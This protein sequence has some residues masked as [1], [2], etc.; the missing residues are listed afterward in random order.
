MEKTMQQTFECVPKSA[1]IQAVYRQALSLAQKSEVLLQS[2]HLVIALF[3]V[4]NKAEKLLREREI[5]EDRLLNALE[6][7]YDEPQDTV[8][9]IIALSEQQASR[10]NANEEDTLHLL[11]ACC[12][13]RSSLAYRMLSR[14]FKEVNELLNQLNR[15]LTGSVKR[16]FDTHSP[17]SYND[18]LSTSASIS[19]P[20]G[21]FSRPPSGYPSHPTTP[22]PPTALPPISS[23]NMS[24]FPPPSTLSHPPH[25]AYTQAPESSSRN[26]TK[27]PQGSHEEQARAA[28]KRATHGRLPEEFFP[29]L[30]QYGRNLTEAAYSG[31]FDPLIGR[32]KEIEHLLDILGKR[33]TNNPCILGDSGVGKTALVQGLACALLHTENPHLR[34]KI[35]IELE[36]GNLLSGT[37]MRGSLSEKLKAIK[38]E[39]ALANGQII[40]FIDEIHTL[41]RTGGGG[42]SPLDI[43]NEL[44]AALASG[45]FPCIG[46]TTNHEY[47]MH[48]ER[49]PALLR[50]FHP[51]WLE[52]PTQEEAITILTSLLRTIYSIHHK[53][54]YLPE[55]I[56]E[57]V[58]L[59]VRYLPE[60]RLPAKA[61]DILDQAGSYVRRLQQHIVERKH[62][63]EI[64]AKTA[65]IAKEHLL[66]EDNYR[67]L[68][69]EDFLKERI[70]GHHAILHQIAHALRR[71]YAGFRGNRPIGSFLFLGSTGTGK[72]EMAKALA[73][74]FFHHPQA[75]VRFDM[76][77]FQESNS[78]SRLIGAP[79]G[80]VGHEEGG[81]LTEA[82]RLRPYRLILLDEI[83]KAHRE[84]LHILLQVL[85]E[86]HLTD[87]KGRRVSFANCIIIMTSNLGS[88][89]LTHKQQ[90]I[91]FQKNQ[92]DEKALE[93][94]VFAAAKQRIRPELWE[95]I[96]G[97]FIF[98]PLQREEVRQIA[99]LLLKQSNQRLQ[100][101][102]Q[103]TYSVNPMILD[104]LIAQG[105]YQE[106]SGARPMRRLIERHLEGFLAE[107]I[108]RQRLKK[109]DHA[110]LT[111]TSEGKI[112]FETTPPNKPQR[113]DP[114]SSHAPLH[115]TL[116]NPIVQETKIPDDWDDDPL[117]ALLSQ[118]PDLWV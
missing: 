50:R 79:P 112:A 68:H 78:I 101:E 34:D 76:S 102:K 73:E 25:H 46:A 61:L 20:S 86:G 62:I 117:A 89:C 98:H 11:Y 105:G 104:W 84:I 37:Q 113:S 48:I 67:L 88:E 22:I 96:E 106:A 40:V 29:S 30:S 65:A 15:Y 49:D 9:Q 97:R 103:I 1:E 47:K 38:E 55:A 41:I 110:V 8:D 14:N 115:R 44:K 32:E 36:V 116:S 5:N 4:P 90:N 56:E 94:A 83:D 28:L 66:V 60:R 71:N 109:G 27:P 108:L 91:G 100:Q 80:Y 69:M 21:F 75:M 18:A 87:S 114:R 45:D 54:H 33:R 26:H 10:S 58:R 93:E 95:R 77:E 31:R 39:V 3:L 111:V 81:Q 74:F 51:I 35:V 52:E 7:A 72:T 24:S 6:G 43:S 85:D 64:V 70:I 16:R 107:E 13:V 2:V 59:S 99:S 42:D 57:A 17:E 19:S 12:R 63:T 82:I 92:Q 118:D 53:V 23:G